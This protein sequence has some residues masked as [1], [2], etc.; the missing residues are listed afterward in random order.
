MYF[1]LNTCVTAFK[2][3][4][5]ICTRRVPVSKFYFPVSLLAFEFSGKICSSKSFP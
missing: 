4:I 1:N 3:N 2:L 5:H